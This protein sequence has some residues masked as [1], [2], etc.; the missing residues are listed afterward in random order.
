MAGAELL[1]LDRP[2][3]VGIGKGG[4]HPVGAVTDDDHDPPA[5][6]GAGGVEHPGEQGAPGRL[7]EHLGQLGAHPL[8]QAGG[9]HD[10]EPRG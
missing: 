7:V 8:A 5:A 3:E 10:G 1:G 6:G 4:A 9:Q 2:L